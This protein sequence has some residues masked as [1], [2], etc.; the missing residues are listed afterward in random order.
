MTKP[1]YI[2]KQM[3]EMDTETGTHVEIA[4]PDYWETEAEY[5]KSAMIASLD[6]FYTVEDMKR[7][8]KALE[9]TIILIEN[10]LSL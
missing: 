9:A 1:T 7:L 10:D 4:L 8:K 6:G 2:I 3:I 5:R